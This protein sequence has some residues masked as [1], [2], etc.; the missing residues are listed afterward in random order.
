MNVMMFV[1]AVGDKMNGWEN[2]RRGRLLE[3]ASDWHELI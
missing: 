2:R 3:E 1:L